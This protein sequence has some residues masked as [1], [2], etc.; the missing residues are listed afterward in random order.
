MSATSASLLFAIATTTVVALGCE[1]RP[2]AEGPVERAEFGVLYGG[3]IQEL[4][5]IP[6]EIDQSKQTLAIRVELKQPAR[7]ELPIRWEVD[8]PGHTKRVRDRRG[9]LGR[10]RLTKLGEGA[11]RPGAERF[12]HTFALEPGDPL[13]LWNVRVIAGDEIVV[14]RMFEVYDESARRAAIRKLS[15]AG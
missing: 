9:R 8:M 6:F 12:D 10:G 3:Q 14:D 5:S 1:R 15:D 4:D 11:V 7:E 13:G 2:Q